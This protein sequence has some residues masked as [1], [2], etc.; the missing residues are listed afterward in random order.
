MAIGPPIPDIQ[1][2]LQNSRSKVKVK[3]TPVS[4]WFSWL[5]SLV[6]HIRASYQL[7]SLSFHD[8]R[9]SH[10]RHT[11]YPSKFKVKVKG[12]PVSAWSSWL[13][14]LVFHIRASYQLPSLS[15]HGNQASHSRHT[16][17]PSKFKVKGT[18]VSTWSSWLISL[19]FHIRVSYRLPSISFHD[20]LA[21]HSR[22]TIWPWKFKVKGQGQEYPSQ[23]SIQLTH[24]L[25]VSHQVEQPFPR[26]GQ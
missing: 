3:G 16:I 7:P 10:S 21:S 22:D 23:R 25:F 18:P 17:W 4:A 13:I 6:F 2:T 26:Y 24:F 15:F 8:N 1:F 12:T 14:S 11:I 5:I 20:N 19:V 9:A